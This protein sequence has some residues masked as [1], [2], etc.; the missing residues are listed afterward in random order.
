MLDFSKFWLQSYVVSD[1]NKN[2][3]N[4]N[5]LNNSGISY[6]YTNIV[7]GFPLRVIFVLPVCASLAT[8]ICSLFYFVLSFDLRFKCLRH[9]KCNPN[10]CRPISLSCKQWFSRSVG[11]ST[12]L[13][14]CQLHVLLEFCMSNARGDSLMICTAMVKGW[15]VRFETE[16]DGR[17][18][19][20]I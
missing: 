9:A 1:P 18:Y 2:L 5:L 20:W 4:Q 6:L 17:S 10:N 13:T 12:P 15:G 8:N 14:V 19:F 3:S 7:T 11:W 16:L